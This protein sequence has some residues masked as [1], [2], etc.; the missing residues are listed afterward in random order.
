MHD[1]VRYLNGDGAFLLLLCYYW[2][3]GPAKADRC[4]CQPSVICIPVV[5]CNRERTWREGRNDRTYFLRR[6]VLHLQL[7]AGES[8][9]D[10]H[11][12]NNTRLSPDFAALT[13][14]ETFRPRLTMLVIDVTGV[15]LDWFV[16]SLFWFFHAI[17]AH[18]LTSQHIRASPFP[19]SIDG[20]EDGH[21]GFRKRNV[22]RPHRAWW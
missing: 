1:G 2:I 6:L 22:V 3:H 17:P 9:C 14:D 4:K 21:R 18:A 11:T 15:S 20:G 8:A 5:L 19:K 13:N 16:T 7:D 12:A 10:E